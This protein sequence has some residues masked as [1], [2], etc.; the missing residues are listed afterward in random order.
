MENQTVMLG[1]LGL[2]EQFK[3][4]GEKAIYRTITYPPSVTPSNGTRWCLNLTT[5]KAKWFFCRVK[6]ARGT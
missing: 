1:S 6:V 4:P 3:V 2:M 5:N